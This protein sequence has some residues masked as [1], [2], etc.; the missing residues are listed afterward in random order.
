MR[1]FVI[2]LDKSLQLTNCGDQIYFLKS[3]LFSGHSQ[4]G[5]HRLLLMGSV[6]E[7]ELGAVEPGAWPF[8]REPEP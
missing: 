1:Y 7:P 6:G 2:S 5:L 3:A 8:K 4:Y